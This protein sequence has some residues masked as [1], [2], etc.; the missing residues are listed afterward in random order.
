[1]ARKATVGYIDT[2]ATAIIT[3]MKKPVNLLN[4]KILA[5]RDERYDKA[6]SS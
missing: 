4:L 2:M 3:R 1:M 6:C 5:D